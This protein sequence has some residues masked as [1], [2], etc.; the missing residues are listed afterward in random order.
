MRAWSDSKLARAL[1]WTILLPLRNAPLAEQFAAVV[2]LHG[3]N[4]NFEANT[5]D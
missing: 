2:A 5:A 4:R 1:K 3:F